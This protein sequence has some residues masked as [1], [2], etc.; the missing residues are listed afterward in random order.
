MSIPSLQ[1]RSNKK[2][3]TTITGFCFTPQDGNSLLSSAV[4]ALY[5]VHGDDYVEYL[6]VLDELL[7][8][9]V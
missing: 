2:D 3:E 7:F 5:G 1:V 4:S 6:H 9:Q 8:D